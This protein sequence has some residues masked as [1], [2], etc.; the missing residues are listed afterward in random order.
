MQE[1]ERLG[2]LIRYGILDTPPDHAFDR[3]TSFAARLLKTPVALISF[4]DS[5]RIWFKSCHG[6]NVDQMGREPGLCASCILQD[7]PWD[8]YRRE[9][10][11]KAL[12]YLVRI[13]G[14]LGGLHWT[15]ALCWA[16]RDD[17]GISHATEAFEKNNACTTCEQAVVHPD[18]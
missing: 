15:C 4:I 2:A 8:N 17:A 6:V 10:G 16:Y 14:K 18:P 7:G 1:Q 3:I 12:R 11:S 5:E 9:S 13:S